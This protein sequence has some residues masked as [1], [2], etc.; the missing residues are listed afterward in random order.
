M[1]PQT[2]GSDP[3]MVPELGPEMG[4]NRVQKGSNPI[5]YEC[6]TLS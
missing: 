2:P 1:G 3:Q 4:Q 6:K 5:G